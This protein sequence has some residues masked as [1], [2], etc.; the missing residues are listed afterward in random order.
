MPRLAKML[1]FCVVRGRKSKISFFNFFKKLCGIKKIVLSKKVLYFNS[2]YIGKKL[3]HFIDFVDF[4]LKKGVFWSYPPHLFSRIKILRSFEQSGILCLM[5]KMRQWMFKIDV[6]TPGTK[7]STFC[8]KLT[9]KISTNRAKH[10][11]KSINACKKYPGTQAIF[12]ILC[13]QMRF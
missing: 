3:S 8:K 6:H 11:I 2:G 12:V 5:I 1:S 9:C 4:T 10:L 13:S 7:Y